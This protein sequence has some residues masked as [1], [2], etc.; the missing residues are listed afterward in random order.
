MCQR[1]DCAYVHP[2][3]LNLMA[4]SQGKGGPRAAMGMGMPFQK[5]TKPSEFSGHPQDVNQN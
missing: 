5:R 2:S 4:G 1:P 3:L